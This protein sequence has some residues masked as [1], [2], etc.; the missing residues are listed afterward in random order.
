M[1]T[2]VAWRSLYFSEC[3]CSLKESECLISQR[4]LGWVGLGWVGLGCG[5]EEVAYLGGGVVC[6]LMLEAFTLLFSWGGGGVYFFGL[7]RSGGCLKSK[8]SQADL[9]TVIATCFLEILA[10]GSLFLQVWTEDSRKMVVF[11]LQGNRCGSGV[12]KGVIYLPPQL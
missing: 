10:L 7:E 11:F 3:V 5:G 8:T 2:S 6:F 1:F 12:T 9:L 4:G